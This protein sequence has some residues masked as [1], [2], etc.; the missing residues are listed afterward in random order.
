MKA[1]SIKGCVS[2]SLA[3]GI[4]RKHYLRQWRYGTTDD[5]SWIK[6]PPGTRLTLELLR[7]CLHY[8]PETGKF[9]WLISPSKKVRKGD[10][11]GS[12]TDYVRIIFCRKIYL[13]HRLA[14]FYMTGVWPRPEVDHRDTVRTNNKW[15][16]LRLA[17]S[18][19]NKQN[20]RRAK[21][22]NRSTRVLGVYPNKHRFYAKIQTSGKSLHLGTFD[23]IEQAHEVYIEAKRRMHEGCTL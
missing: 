8:A 17:T 12:T 6:N 10:E 13:A 9:R 19:V 1:C 3:K 5:P 7:E 21:S 14:W 22:N 23:T 2:P 18:A 16:N 15:G 4:C 11:A 20:Q